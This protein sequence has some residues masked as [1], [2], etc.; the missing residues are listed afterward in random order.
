MIEAKIM[1]HKPNLDIAGLF[2]DPLENRKITYAGETFL[3][4]DMRWLFSV[5]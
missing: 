2:K 3:W 4:L 5:E 1:I